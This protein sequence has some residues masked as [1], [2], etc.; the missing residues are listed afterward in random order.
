MQ[1]VFT[2]EQRCGF[3]STVSRPIAPK[4]SVISWN[5]M[6]EKA[7]RQPPTLT[8]RGMPSL[9]GGFRPRLGWFDCSCLPVEVCCVF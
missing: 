2:Q 5:H 7:D 3:V 4:M 9:G 6:V 8:S 1:M